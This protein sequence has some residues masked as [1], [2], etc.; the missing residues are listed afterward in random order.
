[1]QNQQ[2]GTYKWILN[3]QDH[4]TEFLHLRPLERKSA[5]DVATALLDII[6]SLWRQDVSP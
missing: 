2:N 5:A 1:M 3:Y 6:L 4:F